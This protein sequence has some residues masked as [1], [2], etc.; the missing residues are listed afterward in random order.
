[1]HAFTTMIAVPRHNVKKEDAFVEER[2][3]EAG[4]IAEVWL[5]I[6]PNFMYDGLLLVF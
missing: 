6:K 1:M 5:I 2:Q 4:N 3:L